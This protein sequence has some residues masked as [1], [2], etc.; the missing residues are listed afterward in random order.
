MELTDRRQ[1]FVN[2]DS[3]YRW[4]IKAVLTMAMYKRIP[5]TSRIGR[6]GTLTLILFMK[7]DI[8]ELERYEDEPPPP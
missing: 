1:Q 6:I 5:N 4:C 3:G 8:L 2:I 7:W